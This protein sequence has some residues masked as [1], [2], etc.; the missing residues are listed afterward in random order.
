MQLWN[1]LR[2]RGG[3]DKGT[4]DGICMRELLSAMSD[5]AFAIKYD[6]CQNAKRGSK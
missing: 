5:G 2:R 6:V 3:W 4:Q 1:E